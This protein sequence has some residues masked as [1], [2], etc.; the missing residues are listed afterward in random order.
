MRDR[1]LGFTQK[2]LGPC[3][4]QADGEDIRPSLQYRLILGFSRYIVPTDEIVVALQ[5]ENIWVLGRE[6]DRASNRLFQFQI[7]A[8]LHGDPAEPHNG[9]DAFRIMGQYAPEFFLGFL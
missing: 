4:R 1:P 5:G 6:L 2:D 8:P 9:S 7:T 3:K